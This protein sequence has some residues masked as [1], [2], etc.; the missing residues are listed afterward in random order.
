MILTLLSWIKY[1]TII[2]NIL[3][4]YSFPESYHKPLTILSIIK[5]TLIDVPIT[6][7]SLEKDKHVWYRNYIYL[8]HMIY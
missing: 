4:L 5:T 3:Q 2:V 6:K 7:G 8:Y 1:P